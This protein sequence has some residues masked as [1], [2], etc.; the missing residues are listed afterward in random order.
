[1]DNVILL[2]KLKLLRVSRKSLFAK[3]FF[4]RMVNVKQGIFIKISGYFFF[5][6]AFYI[7]AFLYPDPS[8]FKEIIYGVMNSKH[9]VLNVLWIFHFYFGLFVGAN[10][11]YEFTILDNFSYLSL[12]IL[13]KDLVCFRITESISTAIKFI[14]YFVLPLYFLFY[15]YQ[16]LVFYHIILFIIL[17]LLI[18]LSSFLYGNVIILLMAKAFK[19][20]SPDRL[21]IA[22][23]ISSVW[24]FVLVFRLMKSLQPDSIK[25]KVLNFLGSI[26]T[27]FSCTEVVAN[28]ISAKQM[29][30]LLFFIAIILITLINYLLILLFNKLLLNAYNNLH[31]KSI[32]NKITLT[33][34]KQ[35]LDLK[36]LYS[37]F[38]CIPA[39]LRIIFTKDL[40]IL[41][42]KPYFLLKIFFF[43]IIVGSF[44]SYFSSK[45]INTPRL[46]F[47]YIL[48]S[49]I[50]FRLFIHSIG[51]ERNNILLF[52]QLYP[53]VFRFLIN[54]VKTNLFISSFIVIPIWIIFVVF[55]P[56]LLSTNIILRILLLLSNLIFCTVLLTGYSATFA[57]FKEDNLEYKIFGVPP[58][59]ILL[60]LI[61]GLCV[62]LFFYLVDVFFTINFFKTLISK[63]I[64]I[65][66]LISF[67]SII[68]FFYIG[69]RKIKNY[70]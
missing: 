11:V 32:D 46:L 35:G 19:R 16:G 33:K 53:S 1:M 6:F 24:I 4:K 48:P 52:K 61:F 42:R 68:V 28:T 14:L 10:L 41:L 44:S 23:F 69:N 67:V 29:S 27:N 21:F 13:T 51:L 12:P 49:F 55:D 47:M 65:S 38:R 59:V 64:I 9:I 56:K 22:T 15:L 50:V 7:L 63:L 25:H 2:L 26:F 18:Y 39:E 17:L 43:I 8:I 30:L 3:V 20:I 62:P 60:Y 66:G 36:K 70:F 57:I 31:F 5:V 58:A 45:I 54:R 40:V 37:I 34:K